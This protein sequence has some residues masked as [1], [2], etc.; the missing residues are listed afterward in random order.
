MILSVELNAVAGLLPPFM[1]EVVV[2]REEELDAR[3]REFMAR[4]M[5]EARFA[6]IR[7]GRVRKREV[8]FCGDWDRAAAV[9]AEARKEMESGNAG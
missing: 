3:Q 7:G 4:Y 8:V 6:H 5:P 9:Y 2:T 1:G